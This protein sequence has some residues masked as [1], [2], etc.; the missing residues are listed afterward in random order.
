MKKHQTESHK[1]SQPTNQIRARVLMSGKKNSQVARK[2]TL[3][4]RAVRDWA[5][6]AIEEG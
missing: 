5:R 3:G 4:A 1:P 6:T 2:A